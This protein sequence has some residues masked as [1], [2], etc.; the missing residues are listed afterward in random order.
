[1]AGST[2][3]PEAHL[4]GSPFL[5][6]VYAASS[7]AESRDIY[8][9]WAQQYIQDLE[10]EDYAFP[11]LAAQGLFETLGG[12]L[13]DMDTGKKVLENLSILD[14]GCGT[15]LV[16]LQLAH[17]GAGNVIGLDISPKMLEIAGKTGV[18][19]TL[20]EADLSKPLAQRDD[21][22]DAVICVGTLTR[23]HVGPKPVLKEF[24]RIVK[25]GGLIV[26]TVLDDIWESAGFKT[27]VERLRF[28]G[29]VKVLRSDEVGVRTS[30]T[31]GGRLLV[32]RKC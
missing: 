7:A 30:D 23:G 18:Y 9:E 13:D 4:G 24:A 26:A 20:E 17:F 28:A 16:G 11:K 32:L 8:D 14:A 27:E 2:W 1:M 19:G 22:V 15:G 29:K 25:G 6:R 5:K 3:T 21:S 31:K 12:R 10:A